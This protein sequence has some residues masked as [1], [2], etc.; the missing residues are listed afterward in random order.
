MLLYHPGGCR[1]SSSRNQPTLPTPNLFVRSICRLLYNR[2]HLSW[3]F[4]H[5]VPSGGS[6]EARPRFPPA[7]PGGDAPTGGSSMSAGELL[8]AGRH[9]DGLL[10]PPCSFGGSRCVKL[11]LGSPQVPEQA[12]PAPLPKT[13]SHV[14]RG[15]SLSSCSGGLLPAESR[16][17]L[18]GRFVL[19]RDSEGGFIIFL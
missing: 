7:S 4:R 1:S 17:G 16:G 6:K 12:P 13:T 15:A 2:F 9:E 10:D 19:S 5:S 14:T 11:R 18:I 3:Q 8:K